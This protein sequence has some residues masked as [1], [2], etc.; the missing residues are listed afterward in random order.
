MAGADATA[1]NQADEYIERANALANSAISQI[2]ESRD[3]VKRDINEAK[4]Q[5]D[6]MVDKI[7][8]AIKRY[9]KRNSDLSALADKAAALQARLDSVESLL[10]E[11]EESAGAIAGMIG[12][13]VNLKSNPEVKMTAASVENDGNVL[14]VWMQ[15]GRFVESTIPFAALELAEQEGAAK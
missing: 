2:I 12:K 8:K 7:D 10:G 5:V 9:D 3:S 15:D 6:G 13:V 1:K 4:S 14:C 11:V